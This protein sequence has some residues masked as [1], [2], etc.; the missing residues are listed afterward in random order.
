MIV[1]DGK[2]G[3]FLFYAI[4]IARKPYVIRARIKLGHKDMWK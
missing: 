1:N 3:C 2:V 4:F